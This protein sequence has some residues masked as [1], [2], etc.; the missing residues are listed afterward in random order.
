MK[1]F[2]EFLEIQKN[3]AQKIIDNEY[4]NDKEKIERI[5]DLFLGDTDL[6]ALDEFK[7]DENL[8]LMQE[9]RAEARSD[10]LYNF[11]YKI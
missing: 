6:T 7:N 9:L 1:N 4:Y 8:D 5:N 3:E 10:F 2:K 11:L